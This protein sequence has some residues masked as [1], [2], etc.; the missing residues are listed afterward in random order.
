MCLKKIYGDW[1]VIAYMGQIYLN[2]K[3]ITTIKLYK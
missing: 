3:Q 2:S 1:N